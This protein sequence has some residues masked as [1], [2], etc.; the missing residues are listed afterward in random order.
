MIRSKTPAEGL[1]RPI[2]EWYVA[3][4]CFG[5]AI[6]TFMAYEYMFLS[7]SL[8]YFSTA[9]FSFIG[10]VYFTEG[11]SLANYQRNIRRL[12]YYEISPSNVAFNPSYVALGRGFRWLPIHTQRLRDTFKSHNKEYV[13]DGSLYT[14]VRHFCI[15]NQYTP[16]LKHLVSFLEKDSPLN[17]FRPLPD[18]GGNPAIHGI[19]PKEK[20]F[21]W[22]Y[23]ER[24]GH[25]GIFG[26]S[27]VGK[28]RAAELIISSDIRAGAK[29]LR[30]NINDGNVVI[31]I[32]PKG[33][34]E[35]LRRCV[36]ECIEAGRLDDFY[37]FHLG[38]PEYS[39][40]Y[41]PVAD[42][43]KI[44]EVAGRSTNQVAGE[45]NSAA[46]KEFAWRFAN[47]CSQAMEAVGEEV[48]Y[49]TLSHY[50]SNPEDVTERYLDKILHV[51]DPDW[52]QTVNEIA[53]EIDDRAA[54]FKDR[55]KYVIAMIHFSKDLL[56]AR[57]DN[58]LRHLVGM[59][60]Y[61]KSYYD[62][63]VAS[64]LPFLDK[65]TTGKASRLLNPSIKPT[66]G[67]KRLR[68]R[69]VISRRGVVYIGLDALTDPVVAV[70]V[71]SA[72]LSDL[73]SVSGE[74]YK[75]GS[76]FDE[77]TFKK[78]KS[79]LNK[80][81]Q[82]NVPILLHLDEFNELITGDEII[83]LLNKAGGAG[84][85]AQVYSQTLKDIE[86]KIGSSAKAAQIIGNLQN[87]I[88]MRVAEESTAELLVSK[89]PMVEIESN[90]GVSGTKDSGDLFSGQTDNQ[91]RLTTKED[92]MLRASD[93]MALPKGQ[94]FFLKNG[95]EVWKV[96]FPMF[97]KD[98]LKL[99][100][101]VEAMAKEM[102][103]K[104]HTSDGWAERL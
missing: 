68:W 57:S 41:N 49:E 3:Y 2:G 8:S 101:E 74:I 20:D 35:L 48:S 95:G 61:N 88:M 37:M 15:Q 27:R 18:I 59:L 30:S 39:C 46:F 36:I 44:T 83:Q 73:I 66:P 6:L 1:L 26:Q 103:S 82:G 14:A 42:Y 32:D 100:V 79:K 104:Y 70:A 10:I 91:D 58:I 56:S 21:L 64:F 34:G 99:P 65:M 72:A 93:I 90:T 52:R 45:G 47:I 40:D 12:R 13:V 84:L 86:A 54:S 60:E 98:R 85:I 9:V 11:N 22:R 92:H 81:W 43:Q 7:K 38:F 69:D 63:I 89:L 96:R 25:T 62:K 29:K 16:F 31:V 77:P 55:T 67:K 94:A 80:K 17:P 5:A 78:H 75:T 102:K 97:A 19:E 51:E 87:L 28:T 71:A 33:D 76:N 53:A 24:V 50:I 4:T 23:D